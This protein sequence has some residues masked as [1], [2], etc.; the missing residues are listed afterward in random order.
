MTR[1]RSAAPRQRIVTA[2][3][4]AQRRGRG[5]FELVSSWFGTVWF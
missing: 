4:L 5:T 3:F 2:I 1:R